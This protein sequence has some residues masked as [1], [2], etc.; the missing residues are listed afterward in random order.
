[1]LVGVVEHLWLT[2]RKTYLKVRGAVHKSWLERG[3]GTPSDFLVILNARRFLLT[4]GL[5][6]ASMVARYKRYRISVLVGIVCG[7]SGIAPFIVCL[8]RVWP[9]LYW[10]K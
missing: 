10:V 5:T 2:D 7:L 4:E 3:F 8:V 6:T 1:M 9:E